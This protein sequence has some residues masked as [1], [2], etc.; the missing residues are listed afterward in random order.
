[1]V[2]YSGW[3]PSDKAEYLIAALNEPAAHILHSIPTGA[4]YREVTAIL[5]NCYRDL[6]EAFHAQLEEIG[7]SMPG[8]L[9]KNLLPP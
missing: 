1:V 5:K 7:S 8:N 2:E 9:C 3:T 4:K 6:A